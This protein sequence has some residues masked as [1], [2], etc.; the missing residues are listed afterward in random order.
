[1]KRT[2]MLTLLAALAA[3]ACSSSGPSS[4]EPP[5]GGNTTTGGN[6]NTSGGENTTGG[7]PEAP[8]IPDKTVL[9]DRV[10]SY[11]EALRTASLKLVRNLPTLQQIKNVETATDQRA[12]YEAEIDAMLADQRF[13]ARMIKWWRD[14]MRQGGGA[15][16]NK[17]SRDTAPVFATRVM[18]EEKPYTDLF[19]ATTNTCPTY[20]GATN[21]FT[22]GNCD[23]GVPTHAGVLTNPG[24]MMQFYGNMAFRRVRWVQ[25]IFV[26]TKFPAEY[27]AE[28]KQ[29][30]GADYTG[31]WPFES[32]ATAPID[33]QDTSSVVCANCHVTINR[34]APLFANFN[35]NGQWMNDSQVET[36]TVPDPQKTVLSHWLKDGETTAWRFGEPV[37][38]L[39][40]LG[41]AMAADADVHDCAVA[42][43]YNFAM[44]KE[45]IVSDLA[46][47]P[48]EVLKPYV[49]DFLAN[50]MNLKKTLRTILLSDD[51]T[52][53]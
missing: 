47:V 1:M 5:T 28:P 15:Q 21:T 8:P 7:D 36:P 35:M 46:T 37:A 42:R 11:T 24:V 51:F 31:P 44:S 14:T 25:E 38:D 50:G 45:D 33:F 40:A 41:Q 6:N 20:D 13:T 23:N 3:G 29:V 12:A 9:D 32:V 10:T 30:N 39:P 2:R 22:D 52:K 4:L 34:V 27:A 16:D 18:V 43:M 19:T 48:P 26:C 17:P 49:E 53:F